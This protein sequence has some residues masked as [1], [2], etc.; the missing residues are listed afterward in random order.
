MRLGMKKKSHAISKS[1]KRTKKKRETQKNKYSGFFSFLNKPVIPY[2]REDK[3]SDIGI[4]IHDRNTK[5]NQ[6][7]NLQVQFPAVTATK[8]FKE[9]PASSLQSRPLV[10]WSKQQFPVTLICWD[11]DAPKKMEGGFY[12]HWLVTHIKNEIT[13]GFSYFDWLPPNPPA[14]TGVHRYLFGIFEEHN[15]I[16]SLPSFDGR[17]NFPFSEFTNKNDLQLLD[18]VVVTTSEDR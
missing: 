3:I 5:T 12:I 11:P 14:G 13:D 1:R 15:G 18:W 16:P 8:N 7:V 4:N 2:Q 9:F 6:A 17:T 10:K